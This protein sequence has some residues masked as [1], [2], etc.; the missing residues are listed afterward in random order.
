MLR[1]ASCLQLF[2]S[3]LIIKVSIVD[4]VN[5]LNNIQIVDLLATRTSLMTWCSDSVGDWGIVIFFSRLIGQDVLIHEEVYSTTWSINRLFIS[6]V[7]D[8]VWCLLANILQD[9]RTLR[10]V[11]CTWWRTPNQLLKQLHLIDSV[12]IL[13]SFKKQFKLSEVAILIT[14]TRAIIRSILRY[15]FE[16]TFV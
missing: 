3:W 5:A 16:M 9:V 2:E 1:W 6:Q 13:N 10:R 12:L 14:L 8:L 7:T 15:S 4:L 11:F